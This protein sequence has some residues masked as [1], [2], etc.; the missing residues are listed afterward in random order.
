MSGVLAKK[1][2]RKYSC[3]PDD[4]RCSTYSTSSQRA[5]FHVKYV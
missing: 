2:G 1:L 3:M 4:A 5:F